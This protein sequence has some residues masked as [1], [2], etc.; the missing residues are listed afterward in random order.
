LVNPLSA[1]SEEYSLAKKNSMFTR[2]T[3]RRHGE[4]VSSAPRHLCAL[5]VKQ[6][7]ELEFYADAITAMKR[8]LYL[9]PNPR[10]RAA[11]DKIYEWEL[12]SKRGN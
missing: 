5:L 9:V 3:S 10:S 11:Q 7:G 1:V 4:N 2:R 12:K 8:Y 6:E